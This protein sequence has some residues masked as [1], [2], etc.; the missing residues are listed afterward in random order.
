[1]LAVCTLVLA[2]DSALLDNALG[3]V[4]GLVA[5]GAITAVEEEIAVRRFLQQDE[6]LLLLAKHF[7]SSASY[8]GHL[9]AALGTQPP[10][11]PTA[12][13]PPLAATSNVLTTRRSVKTYLADAVPD[14]VLQRGPP[15]PSLC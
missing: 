4:G 8:V 11:D 3:T 2:L 12:A 14:A 15:G 1:M 5:A 6:P 10:D 7:G 13:Q 9:R